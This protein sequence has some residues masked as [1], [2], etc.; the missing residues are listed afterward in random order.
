MHQTLVFLALL[1]TPV[2][3][4]AQLQKARNVFGTFHE[5]IT[6]ADPFDVGTGIYF[7][8]Y[9]DLYIEDTIPINFVRTQ[10]NMDPRSRSFGVGAST[11]YDMFIVGDVYKFSWVALVLADGSQ[12]RY[13]RIS[14][15]TGFADGVFE[16]K[17]TLDKFF[18]SRIVW[19]KRGGW[20]VSLR[21]GTEYSVQGCGAK[22]KPGQCAV[23]E[24]KNAQGDRLTIQRDREGNI[25]QIASPHGHTVSIENDS[26]GR[27]KKA[28]DDAGHW[29]S[30]E[31]DEHGSLKRTVNWR[32]EAQQFRYDDRFNMVF[33]Q[34]TTPAIGEYPACEVTIKNWYDEKN[35]FAGQ[36]VSNG[37]FADVKYTTASN[38][39]IR[40]VSMHSDQGFTHFFM[41]DAGYEIRED[42]SRGKNDHWSLRR[43][44]DAETNAVTDLRL[45]CG[46]SEIK[47][48]VKLDGTL[49]NSDVYIPLFS[50]VCAEVASK[51]KAEPKNVSHAGPSSKL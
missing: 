36:K 46:A 3:T 37:M 18:G 35:R 30:Y 6:A 42:F 10:R 4:V 13:A 25:L 39:E 40:E 5:K 24:M 7:R 44:R 38:G 33:A 31:Y 15:G 49:Q 20:T 8:E 41:N 29:V 48:P 23:K 34:E 50:H 28:T 12:E 16:N 51:R 22:S 14:P 9:R 47:V 19:N 32:G 17:T 11:S 21:D 2:A 1:A 26:D 45:R 43:I 27:I